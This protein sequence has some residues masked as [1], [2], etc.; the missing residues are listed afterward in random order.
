MDGRRHIV[1]MHI[2]GTTQYLAKVQGMPKH[3]EDK[4]DKRI[5]SFMWA[6]KRQTPVNKETLYAPI[7]KGGKAVLDIRARNHAIE[8]T[9]VKEYLD[10]G[11]D[12]PLWALV[13]DRIL[14]RLVP[15]TE[16]KIP[17]TLRQ[18]V[19]LQ[20]WKVKISAAP[21]RLRKLLET[22]K[23]FGIRKEGLAFERSILRSM[24]IWYHSEAE[25][26]LRRLQHSKASKCLQENHHVMSVGDAETL[27]G[28]LDGPGHNPRRNCAC[29]TCKQTRRD[30][31]CESPHACFMRAKELL[32]L[33]PEKWDPR[34]PKP[35]DHEMTHSLT[36]TDKELLQE[37][38]YTLFN[39][40]VTTRGNL[41][42][43]FRVFT[44]GEVNNETYQNAPPP[45]QRPRFTIA[46]DGSCYNN[47]QADARAGAG[48]YAG[49]ERD[50]NFSL[51]LPAALM[52]SNQTGELVAVTEA[53]RNTAV[54]D[55]LMIESDSEYSID[56]A[57]KRRQLHEDSG[58]I[59]VMNAPVIRVMVGVLRQRPLPTIFRWVKGHRGH[60]LNEGADRLAG[61]G[62]MKPEPDEIDMS[63]DERLKISGAKLK[64]MTQ[65]LAYQ[66][67]REQ[68]MIAYETRR[69]TEDNMTRAIDNIEVFFEESP[70]EAHIWK[71]IRHKDIRREVRYFLWMILHDAYMIGTNW[72]RPGYSE[73]LQARQECTFCGQLESMEHILSEC[74][75]P[76]QQEV[77]RLAK[78]L[79][80]GKNKKWPRPSLGAVISSPIAPFKSDKSKPK[81]G[82]ARLYRIIMTE[83][84][85]LIW[86]LRCER[87]IGG[88]EN[89]NQPLATTKEIEGRWIHAIND[90]LAVDCQMTNSNRYGKKAIRQSLVERTWGGILK[91][92]EELPPHWARGRTE[93]LVGIERSDRGRGRTGEG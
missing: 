61:E 76:G 49:E 22:A 75:A 31:T 19:F 10:F 73:E 70:T 54:N 51:R 36:D 58:Y 7:T 9:W 25:S 69:R 28:N 43:L 1:Q 45:H 37:D 2:G 62:A 78:T 42:E 53:G 84:A 27:A 92:E 6:D 68:K 82:D 12:R 13:A 81:S 38:N 80:K 30:I 85:Y 34:R 47:G 26:R 46:T 33:L 71:G 21:A 86:K 39:G 29:T 77:W 23:K 88:A 60:Q 50:E 55:P 64:M 35:E 8:I 48:G 66:G 74:E 65:K 17:P 16:E 91:N 93:V 72:Q 14:A 4:L 83:S 52:Q 79:W 67:I 18:N 20:S 90:R 63:I 56:E 87:V 3:V 59:G 89:P 41:T 44:T 57:N 32:D 5:R 40:A 15:K 24:P 11:P